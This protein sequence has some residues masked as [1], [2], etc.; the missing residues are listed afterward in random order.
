MCGQQG[1]GGC[2]SGRSDE[3]SQTLQRYRLHYQGS[4]TLCMQIFWMSFNIQWTLP[5]TSGVPLMCGTPDWAAVRSKTFSERLMLMLCGCRKDSWALLTFTF[6]MFTL[7][8]SKINITEW[9]SCFSWAQ[10]LLS[11]TPK[12]LW[13]CRDLKLY[14]PFFQRWA[15]AGGQGKGAERATQSPQA[16]VK[17]CC[18]FPEAKPLRIFF[19]SSKLL[20][21]DK[22]MVACSCMA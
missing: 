7:L 2:C 15:H 13:R 1:D 5:N 10:P 9:Y 18:I 19:C 21:I 20:W 14:E 3:S 8:L 17:F 16:L 22:P 12:L 6:F 4:A 11:Q